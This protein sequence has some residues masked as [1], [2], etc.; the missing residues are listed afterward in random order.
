MDVTFLSGVVRNRKLV[1]V[2]TSLLSSSP[3]NSSQNV[4]NTPYNQ[5][6][7]GYSNT[8]H[9]QGP[10]VSNSNSNPSSGTSRNPILTQV[11]PDQF[12]S[13]HNANSDYDPNLNIFNIHNN[14]YSSMYF[15]LAQLFSAPFSICDSI[16]RNFKLRVHKFTFQWDLVRH[17]VLSIGSLLPFIFTGERL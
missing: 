5:S 3:T 7:P 13:D 17:F 16:T 11:F 12:I 15:N 4:A 2:S 6:S 1:Q 9:G 8:T 14:I 10:I